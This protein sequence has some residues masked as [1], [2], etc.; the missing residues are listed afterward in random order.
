MDPTLVYVK[1]LNTGRNLA[2]FS[3]AMKHD[4]E[5]Y[6]FFG[7]RIAITHPFSQEGMSLVLKARGIYV[8]IEIPR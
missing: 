7:N 8:S 5:A 3:I 1:I 4:P 6:S 2:L